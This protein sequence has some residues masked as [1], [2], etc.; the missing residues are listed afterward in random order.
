M[1]YLVNWLLGIFGVGLLAYSA[2]VI[3]DGLRYASREIKY[4]KK[5]RKAKEDSQK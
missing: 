3:Y 4:A 5:V 1:N 2:Y